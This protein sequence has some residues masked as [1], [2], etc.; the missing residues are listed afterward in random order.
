MPDIERMPIMTLT[1][2]ELC[3]MLK[4]LHI[5]NVSPMDLLTL[6]DALYEEID[7]VNHALSTLRIGRH[8]HRSSL[9]KKESGD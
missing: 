7:I 3:E 5:G 6:S 8:R 2:D 9:E 4:D 1:P